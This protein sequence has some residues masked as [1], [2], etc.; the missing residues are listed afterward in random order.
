MGVD[1]Q[2][3]RTFRPRTGTAGISMEISRKGDLG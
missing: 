1:L 3:N 2:M